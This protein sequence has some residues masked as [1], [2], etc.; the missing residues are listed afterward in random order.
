MS[1]GS[2]GAKATLKT[3]RGANMDSDKS[4]DIRSNNI[5][6]AKGKEI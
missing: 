6:A 3:D 2:N 1:E 5:I 4:K